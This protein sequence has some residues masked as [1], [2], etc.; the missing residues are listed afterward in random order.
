[1]RT[2][3]EILDAM[4]PELQKNAIKA[5]NDSHMFSTTL[6]QVPSPS[7]LNGVVECA[8]DSAHRNEACA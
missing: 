8:D 4:S 7:V 2:T 6:A 1:M 5:V 3:Q